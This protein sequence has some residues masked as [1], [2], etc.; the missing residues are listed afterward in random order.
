[1]KNTFLGKDFPHGDKLGVVGIIRAETVKFRKSTK[2]SIYIILFLTTKTGTETQVQVCD[3][4]QPLRKACS[5]L[6][7]PPT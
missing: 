5:I 6:M 1:M 3:R 2:M 4:A 7:R